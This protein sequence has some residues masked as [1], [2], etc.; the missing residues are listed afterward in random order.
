MNMSATQSQSQPTP[1]SESRESSRVSPR[2]AERDHP[3]RDGFERA[4]QA[5]QQRQE[6]QPSENSEEAP[7]DGG[8]AAWMSVLPPPLLPMRAAAVP[9]SVCA[10]GVIGETSGTRAVIEASLTASP[11]EAVTPLTGTDP[12][13]LWE[14]SVSATNAVPMQMRAERSGSTETHRAWG[15]TI[16][17]PAGNTEM[18]ARHA[19]RLNE[20]LRKHAV[21]LSHVRIEES[22]EDKS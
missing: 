4:L 2:V 15:L 3:A 16:A 11:G 22:D 1:R 9:A 14:V 5:R 17:S 6:E 12:A 8:A 20:R 10:A 7:A 18:M 21:G 19:P 13:A